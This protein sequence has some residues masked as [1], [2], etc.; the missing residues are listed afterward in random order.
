M[1]CVT[2]CGPAAGEGRDKRLANIE[3]CDAQADALL[4]QAEAVPLTLV[5][6]QEPSFL[7]ITL[8]L[9]WN[10][11]VRQS[12]THSS[13]CASLLSIPCLYLEDAIA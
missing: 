12:T 13:Y 4:Q 1:L 11:G 7:S 9:C 2:F 10:E 6:V 3:Q 8:L 5:C